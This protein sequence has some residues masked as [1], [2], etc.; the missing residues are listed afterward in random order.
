[1]TLNR[2]T[3]LILDHLIKRVNDRFKQYFDLTQI[4]A[5]EA[6][7]A[8]VTCPTIKF[9]WLTQPVTSQFRL[10]LEEI[11]KLVIDAGVE[12]Q[13]GIQKP[14]TND[15]ETTTTNGDLRF[16][17]FET[18]DDPEKNSN[19]DSRDVKE[20]L[21]GKIQLNLLQY[22]E[23]K[24]LGFDMLNDYPS[25]KEIFLRYNSILPSSAPVERLFSFAGMVNTP[26]RQKL[27]DDVFEMLV[28]LKANG[29]E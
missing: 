12:L 3:T 17:E 2:S 20:K 6:I 9:R 10:D 24:R 28:L 22:L 21:I 13:I 4:E 27:S 19:V 25:I 15:E 11:K 26:K 16:F 8:A 23:D 29:I 1:M 5:K 18:D 14:D 7:I